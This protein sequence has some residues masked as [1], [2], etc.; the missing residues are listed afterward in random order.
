MLCPSSSAR[1][2]CAASAEGSHDVSRSDVADVA[3]TAAAEEEEEEDVKANDPKNFLRF[4]CCY[5]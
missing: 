3:D 2:R 1:V 4:T 5:I